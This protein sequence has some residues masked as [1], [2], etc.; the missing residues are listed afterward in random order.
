M[1]PTFISS[2]AF[3][4]HTLNIAE[5]ALLKAALVKKSID[6]G[7]E[8]IGFWGKIFGKEANYLVC[9]GNTPKFSGVPTK[10]FY[11]IVSGGENPTAE[12]S[13]LSLKHI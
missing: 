1:D 8:F 13:E 7:L 2:L 3:S 11:Y 12:L 6:E 4:G 5:R 9:V 10:K